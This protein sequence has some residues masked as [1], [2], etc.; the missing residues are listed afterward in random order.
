MACRC[1]WGDPSAL[2]AGTANIEEFCSDICRCG[3]LLVQMPVTT[4]CFLKGENNWHRAW[5][6]RRNFGEAI[7]VLVE[8]TVQPITCKRLNTLHY[9]LMD[10]I[11]PTDL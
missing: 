10:S 1:P 9:V 6:L 11:S 3:G 7:R 8:P 5:L 4:T 2:Q